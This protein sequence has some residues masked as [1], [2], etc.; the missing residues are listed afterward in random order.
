[1][2]VNN[3]RKI[4]VDELIRSAKQDSKIVCLDSDSK[5]SSILNKFTKKFP[6]R[7]F[8]F[9]IAEQNMVC[10]AGGM[11]TLG[12]IPFVNSYGM[13][14]AMRALDQLRNSIAYS[15]LNVKFVLTHHGLDSGAD[16]VTH[17]L[18]EDISIF[19]SIA[20]LK[21]LQPADSIEMKQMIEFAIKTHGPIIIKA[22]KTPVEDVFD[23]NFIWEYGK[24]SIIK[25]GEKVA[26][27]AVGIMVQKAIKAQKLVM[28]KLGFTPMVINL[29]SLTDIDEQK[30]V[31]L[32]TD[33]ELLV[34]VEDHSI[35]GGLGGIVSEILSS[36][37]PKKI[38]RVGLENT[39]AE[40]G[41]PDLLYSRY[42]MDE[43]YILKVISDNLR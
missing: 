30:L 18:T 3:L 36:H 1:M 42:K 2:T 17:Q 26:I 27:I 19:R 28:E 6:D 24:P 11:A 38:I 8:T 39:F 16:G 14:I 15:N 13:F 5:E 22:G 29:S 21:V 33:C 32:V 43:N 4:Y 37:S 31:S 40:C 12:L 20:N 10:A 34:T 9:G 7:S 25:D 35:Y 41:S 23:Q